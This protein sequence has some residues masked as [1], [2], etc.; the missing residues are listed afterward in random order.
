M[1]YEPPPNFGH[2]MTDADRKR[3][4]ELESLNT[5]TPF[6]RGA[7]ETLRMQATTDADQA[8]CAE[9]AAKWEAAE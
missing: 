4:S 6:S 8:R 3:L 2:P 5:P 9:I 7:L 1:T